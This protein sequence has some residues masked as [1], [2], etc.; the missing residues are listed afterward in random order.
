MIPL[1]LLCGFYEERDSKYFTENDGTPRKIL[2]WRGGWLTWLWG[3]EEDGIDGKYF[4][5][6]GF[7][8]DKSFF[9]RVL[10][11]SVM[12]NA[13]SNIRFIPLLNLR[14]TPHK[15]SSIGNCRH[16]I[17]ALRQYWA[18]GGNGTGKRP[19]FWSFTTQGL[20]SGFALKIP[21]SKTTAH[22]F[23]IGWKIYPEDAEIEPKSVYQYF[24]IS[25]LWIWVTVHPESDWWLIRVAF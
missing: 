8:A 9:M 22:R 16:P 14:I 23:M 15:I 5:A 20:Y 19:I 11:W 17:T 21:T 4:S 2:A 6:T 25:P 13:V 7:A 1:L 3:N 10:Q 18:A 12:R 24:Q